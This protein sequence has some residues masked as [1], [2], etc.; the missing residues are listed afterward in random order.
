MHMICTYALD[1][2]ANQVDA[3]HAKE[4]ETMFLEP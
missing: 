1:K 3:P 4:E 2:E